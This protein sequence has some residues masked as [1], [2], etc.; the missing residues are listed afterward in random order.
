MANGWKP[1]LS[2]KPEKSAARS[3]A[4][5]SFPSLALMAISQAEAALTI[6][7]FLVSAMIFRAVRVS[8]GSSESHHSKA[9]VSRSGRKW[10][11]PR[12]SARQSEGAQKTQV[13]HVT[14]LSTILAG[15]YL[16]SRRPER[17]EL[18]VLT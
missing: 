15:V 9:Y 3:V 2:I 14:C 5:G 12:P 17:V 7:V 1:S 18:L 6:S 11:T 10:P 4:V 13:Q 8:A 16:L